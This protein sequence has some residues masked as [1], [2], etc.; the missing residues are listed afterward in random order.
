MRTGI[1]FEKC[2]A[3]DISS[4]SKLALL[5]PSRRREIHQSRQSLPRHFGLPATVVP[6]Q[7]RYHS[8]QIDRDENAVEKKDR[9]QVEARG[10][11][12]E[13]N[14]AAQ[15]SGS[16]GNHVVRVKGQQHKTRRNAANEVYRVHQNL[17]RLINS[18]S[19]S[20]LPHG[21][22]YA[23]APEAGARYD[24]AGIRNLRLSMQAPAT[25]S[26]RSQSA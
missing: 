3:T 11:D 19:D 9:H 7:G 12:D 6:T 5:R 17:A 16:Q 8:P 13:R 18:R 23:G 20:S 1:H 26:A 25:G 10:V 24:R 2:R 22:T 14:I 15:R 4:V 21:A